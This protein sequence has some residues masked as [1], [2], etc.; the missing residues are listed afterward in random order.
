MRRVVSERENRIAM[1]GRPSMIMAVLSDQDLA[2]LAV[3]P[4]MFGQDARLERAPACKTGAET[5]AGSIPAL[6]TDLAALR[7]EGGARLP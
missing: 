3:G 1:L 6:T 7:G 2:A 5:Q 4:L